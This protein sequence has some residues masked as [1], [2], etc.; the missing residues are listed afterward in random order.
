MRCP[1]DFG[2][3]DVYD[4]QNTSFTYSTETVEFSDQREVLSLYR[5]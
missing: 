5:K 2:Y 1:A 4:S 3:F